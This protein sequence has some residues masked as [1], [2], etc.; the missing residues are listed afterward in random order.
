ML[1]RGGSI[2]PKKHVEETFELYSIPAHD[3]G[4]PEILKGS[5][6]GSSKSC[7]QPNDVLLSKIVPHIRRCWVVGNAGEHRL[8]GSGEWIIFRSEKV[9]PQYLK[10]FLTSDIF[11]KQFMNTVAGVGGS[12][13]RARPTEVER[14]EIPLP[15]LSE[16]KRIAAILDKADQLRQKRQQAINLA[17]EFL[18]SVFLDMFGTD[19]GWECKTVGE[20][21]DLINGRAFKSTE[22][23]KEGLPI[24]RIQ[25]LKN[26]SAEYNYYAGHYDE[27]HYVAKGD[28]LLSW[29][30][31]LVSFGVFTWNDEPGLL[32][33]H[34]F[35]VKPRIKLDRTY[36]EFALGSIVERAKQNFS[37]IDM[38]HITKSELNKYEIAIPP[39]D[40]QEQFALVVKKVRSMS[41]KVDASR[42][43]VSEAFIALSQKAFAGEL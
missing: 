8:M 34:I 18:R 9:F 25:N 12:L 36:L 15:P 22:W 6:I 5:E 27:K 37:G 14:I 20:S 19:Q 42:K 35:N 16:Q 32:N 2:N 29:A 1:K 28:I 33:Q 4:K 13:V 39:A 43:C 41:Y 24:I 40:V 31:Q 38:K 11:H 26:S 21:L 7:I 3:A 17:D 23:V 30:G 10:Y